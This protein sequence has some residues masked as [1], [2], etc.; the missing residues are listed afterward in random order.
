MTIKLTRNEKQVLAAMAQAFNYDNAADEKADNAVTSDV[1]ELAKACDKSIASTRGIVGNLVKK[2]LF[3]EM[4]GGETG[5]TKYIGITDAGIDA[6]YE[7]D[8]FSADAGAQ[9]NVEVYYDKNP[10][11]RSWT[12]IAYDAEGNQV[13]DALYFGKRDEAQRET[14]TLARNM[15][16]KGYTLQNS[17][18]RTVRYSF[19][20]DKV[21]KSVI[22]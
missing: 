5:Q 16:L 1:P 14:E 2:G 12:V 8:T 7:M 15:G 18:G 3:C 10:E 22:G 13:G 9:G 21:K 11:V 17:R 4:M 20:G 19:K 6:F